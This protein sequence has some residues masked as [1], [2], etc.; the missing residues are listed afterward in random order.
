MAKIMS[1]TSL[2]NRWRRDE[3]GSTAIVYA[4]ILPVLIG[5]GAL[6]VEAG[7]YQQRNA[8]IQSAADMAAIAAALEYQA[9][10]DRDKTELAARGDAYENGY[11]VEGG[12]IEVE[13]PIT[14]GPFAGS[15][16]ALVRI[17][18]KQDRFFSQIFP[19][20]KDIIHKVEATVVA[21]L[22]AGS[23]V[24]ALSLNESDSRAIEI[25]GNTDVNLDSCAIHTNSSANGAFRL[26]G[27]GEF[28]GECISAVGTVDIA[29][30]GDDLECDEPLE[31]TAAV[32]DPY[33]DVAIDEA[34]VDSLP[35]EDNVGQIKK[36]ETETLGPGR[37]C[38]N[39]TLNGTLN[40]EP[41]T[42]YFDNADLRFNG[43]SATLNA[44]PPDGVT[45]VFLN[46]GELG[47]LNGGDISIRAQN[48]GTFAG[49]A[50]YGDPESSN[51]NSD[52][53]INGNQDLS[54]EG[55]IYFPNQDIEF[56]GGSGFNSSCTQVIGNT[57]KF[58]GNSGLTVTD[59]APLGT[60]EITGPPSGSGTGVKLVN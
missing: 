28:T 34:L 42:Y 33:A 22:G 38:S 55:A 23:P 49:I 19:N 60:S 39:I 50:L 1:N 56:S 41:G 44:A 27:S 5:M 12:T 47:Q 9:T 36:N 6:A 7:H 57:I 37:Y 13:S 21:A 45:L 20:N 30:S 58:T 59:C 32:V 52:I 48:S 16:G 24:C 17:T 53:K 29:N 14:T 31:N 43:N 11:V 25:T 10:N 26:G 18:Q 46:G 51:S 4:I 15:E 3:D 8:R 54:I 40:L 35:C 2:L